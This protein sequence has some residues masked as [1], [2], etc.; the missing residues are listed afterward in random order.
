MSK[1]L[2]LSTLLLFLS[3]PI[4]SQTMNAILD[5]ECDEGCDAVYVTAYNTIIPTRIWIMNDKPTI[6]VINIY[7]V[8]IH[9]GELESPCCDNSHIMSGFRR[10]VK[11]K[12]TSNNNLES[13]YMYKLKYRGIWYYFNSDK[14]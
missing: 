7:Y 13:Q 10:I 6:P 14:I 1:S 11:C 8:Y 12:K 9:I 5:H 2:L 3:V 4:F